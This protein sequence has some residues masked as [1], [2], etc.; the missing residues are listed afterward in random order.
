MRYL[1]CAT[2]PLRS[3]I[4]FTKEKYWLEN[5]NR[6]KFFIDYAEQSGFD[7]LVPENWYSVSGVDVMNFKV[8]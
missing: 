2:N 8:C 4:N 6:R 1:V 7:P 3:E 5:D